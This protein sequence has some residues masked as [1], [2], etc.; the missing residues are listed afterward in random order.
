MRT[1]L[2]SPSLKSGR[3]APPSAAEKPTGH[4][5][6]RRPGYRPVGVAPSDEDVTQGGHVGPGLPSNT[7]L[8]SRRQ[9]GAGSQPACGT[10]PSQE[11][12]LSLIFTAC[13]RVWRW[14]SFNDLGIQE[15]EK[16]ERNCSGRCGKGMWC[17]RSPPATIQSWMP[18][19]LDGV[20]SP[21]LQVTPSSTKVMCKN[22]TG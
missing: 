16:W 5:A 17:I 7:E 9:V 15:A 21:L 22:L 11:R 2:E 4:V 14:L 10:K 6:Q 20:P 3:R 18:L 19:L 1:E 8:S 12:H 13:P